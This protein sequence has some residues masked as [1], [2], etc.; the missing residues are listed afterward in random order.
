MPI[1][2]AYLPLLCNLHISA[3]SDCSVAPDQGNP[4]NPNPITP[5]T[6]GG[7]INPAEPAPTAPAPTAPAPTNPAPTEAT[8]TEPTPT[9]PTPTEPTPTEPTPT[10]PVN[11]APTPGGIRGGGLPTS[12]DAGMIGDPHIMSWSGEWFDY[13]G[14]W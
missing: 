13:S 3:G 5:E 9:N 8:P 6:P 10:D 4:V 12:H 11:P 2:H 7:I 1:P 14:A